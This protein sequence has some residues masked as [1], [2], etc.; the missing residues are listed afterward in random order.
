LKDN[1]QRLPNALTRA[2][3]EK[4]LRDQNA[5]S[6]D[7]LRVSE[8]RNRDLVENSVYG[9][10]RVSMDGNFL[11]ANPALLRIIGCGSA[12]EVKS[13]N[14]GQDFFRFPEQHSQF[15]KKCREHGQIHGV[16]TEWR[17]R[18]GGFVTVRLTLRRLSIPEHPDAL[19]IIAEDVTELRAMERQLRQAQKFEAIG[20]SPAGSRMTSTTWWARS[21]VGR[22]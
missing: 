19:E 18:D 17:R 11:D 12:Q 9:I 20:N 13:L 8:A 2:L 16:E 1:L 3:A 4:A 22:S 15:M 7:A 14:L 10:F 5:K 6:Q 21:W